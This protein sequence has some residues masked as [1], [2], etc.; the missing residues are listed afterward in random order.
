MTREEA[1][2]SAVRIMVA[3]LHP[4]RVYLI[5]STARGDARAQSDIDF[6]IVLPD[7]APR[8]AL[9]AGEIY[10]ALWDIP[11]AIEIVRFRR[12]AFEQ[13]TGWLMSLPAIAMREGKLLYEAEPQVA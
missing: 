11:Y 8:E 5:G 4:E 10:S 6:L 7:S 12:S 2:Q 9:W 1:V 13:R 3:Q